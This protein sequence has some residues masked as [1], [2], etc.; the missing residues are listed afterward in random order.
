MPVV[1][2]FVI[3]KTTIAALSNKLFAFIDGLTLMERTST[4]TIL[5]RVPSSAKINDLVFYFKILYSIFSMLI[6]IIYKA[7]YLP[8]T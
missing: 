2:K 3:L 1:C 7:K 4:N 8:L 5:K 6:P